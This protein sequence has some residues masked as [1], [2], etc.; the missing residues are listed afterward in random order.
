MP[1]LPDVDVYVEHLARRT[2]GHTL[3]RM[4]LASPFLLRTAVPPITTVF[5]Q[6][7]RDVSRLGKRIVFSFAP[8]TKQVE[9]LH[10]VIH[11]MI[12][13]RFRWKDHGAAVPGKIG[14]AAFDFAAA[15][16]GSKAAKTAP[17]KDAGTLLLT[18]ASGKKRASLH[19]VRGAEALAALAPDGLEVL[20]SGPDAFAERLRSE[21]HTL[22][23]A[24][25]DPHLFSGIGNAYSDEILHHARMSPVTD[26]P[27]DGRGGSP[28]PRLDPRGAHAVARPPA[29]ALRRL[30]GESH[31]V[32]A[33][34]GGARQVRPAVPAL[35]K[36]GA[37]HPLRGQRD[38]L[39]PGVPDRQQAARRSIALAADE[40]RLAKDT[41]GARGEE[42]PLAGPAAARVI[43]AAW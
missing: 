24:L 38:E 35:R 16:T 26:L 14:L 22:K 21:N 37:A 3:E 29:R 4:R 31:R 33:G 9:P 19:L 42:G 17:L 5:G 13:G 30:P 11:L 6:E 2:V 39:L 25:T 32:P 41:R 7:V 34:D 8:E 23:R 28:P 15:G 43:R 40:G 36:A 1:E 18:E 27:P 10:L 20:A 12:A